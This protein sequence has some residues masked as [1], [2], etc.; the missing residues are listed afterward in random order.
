MSAKI[1]LLRVQMNYL[2]IAT[3]VKLILNCIRVSR[4]GTGQ[5]RRVSRSI[6]HTWAIIA[7]QGPISQADDKGYSRSQ[8]PESGGGSSIG[9]TAP[10]HRRWL[11]LIHALELVRISPRFIHL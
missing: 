7:S 8:T 10:G 3:W 1:I 5:E 6:C 4:V 11:L 2:H 9:E